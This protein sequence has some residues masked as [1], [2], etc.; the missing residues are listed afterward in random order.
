MLSIFYLIIFLSLEA[1][2]FC[3]RRKYYPLPLP[4]TPSAVLLLV[5]L[6]F[7]LLSFLFSLFPALPSFPSSSPF[8][9]VLFKHKHFRIRH[10][11]FALQKS[12][13]FGR[14]NL[15]SC[16][17]V[18]ATERSASSVTQA[19]ML[20]ITLN[21]LMGSKHQLTNKQTFR[22]SALENRLQSR[23][24]P[25]NRSYESSVRNICSTGKAPT[26]SSETS[27]RPL[28]G[29]G[30]QLCGQPSRST[31]SAPTSSESSKTYM[32]R[33]LVQSSSTAA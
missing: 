11:E 19:V 15:V 22:K 29:F 20:K 1:N 14:S 26:I 4:P 12:L 16:S 23:T 7:L 8:P 5:L 32:T 6:L 2:T 28:I 24:A 31:T 33:P 27:R 17:S 13:N 18:R 10:D 3:M 30:M 9:L 21:R 25:Q